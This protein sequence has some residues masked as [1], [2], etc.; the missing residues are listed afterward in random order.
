MARKEFMYRGKTLAELKGLSDKEVIQLLPARSRRSI[1]RGLTDAQK[2]LMKVIRS[3][4]K[5][6]KTHCRDL[7]VL[8]IMIGLTI[9]VYRGNRYERVM[10]TEEMIGHRLGE[11]VLT[12]GGVRHSAPGIGAT[13]SSGSISV[14]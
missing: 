5:N 4:S 12:R 3:G 14:K 10:I 11:F 13:R 6:I 8:P 1:Q 9:Q 7:V 2:K